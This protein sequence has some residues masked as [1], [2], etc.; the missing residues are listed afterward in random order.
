VS[1]FSS[2]R[3]APAQLLVLLVIATGVFS[4]FLDNVTTM[5]L[6]APVTIE[7]CKVISLDPIPL[8]MSEIM[9]SNLGGE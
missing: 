5:L 6:L 1:F 8:L 7:L 3:S 4:A 2:L 9:F